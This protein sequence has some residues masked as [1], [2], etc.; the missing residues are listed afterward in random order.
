M[1]DKVTE[2]LP[3]LAS[4]STG[5]SNRAPVDVTKLVLDKGWVLDTKLDG[6]RAFWRNGRLLNR[7]GVD[8]TKKFPEVVA[9]L[10]SAGDLWL[11]GE[12]VS[13]DGKFETV[14]Q[15]EKLEQSIRIR[16]GSERHPCVLIA[17]DLPQHAGLPWVERRA[18]LEALA[19]ERGFATTPISYEVEFI[20]RVRDLQMEGVIVKRPTARYQFG[21]RSPDWVKHK[22]THRVSCLIAGYDQGSG[23]R[24]HLGALLL[25]LLDDDGQVVSIG[26]CGSG[27]NVKQSW[28]LKAR[29]DAAEILVAEIECLNVTSGGTLRFPVFRGLR[30]DVAPTDCLLSQLDSVPRSNHTET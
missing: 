3:M 6:I 27:F 8:M 16:P 11:D 21:K 29:L 12:I 9:A 4:A 20:D 17:F 28:A 23:G 14:A 26:R 22:F 18:L 30:T 24:S 13:L 2:V 25:A 19:D 5:A 10:E 7:R 1:A 15:R